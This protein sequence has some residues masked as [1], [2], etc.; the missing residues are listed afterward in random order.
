MAIPPPESSTLFTPK[1]GHR[2][3]KPKSPGVATFPVA[4]TRLEALLEKLGRRTLPPRRRFTRRAELAEGEAEFVDSG[5]ATFPSSRDAL[6][7]VEQTRQSIPAAL[8][9]FTPGG[10]NSLKAKPSLRSSG[11]ATFPIAPRRF[12]KDQ[13]RRPRGGRG[14]ARRA[15]VSFPLRVQGYEA[16]RLILDE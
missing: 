14:G 7:P 1:Y 9:G 6:K 8:D 10:R 15:A 16:D 13:N 5:A 4:A 11:A 2:R 12:R 3:R